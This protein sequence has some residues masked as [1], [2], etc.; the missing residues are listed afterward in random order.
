MT[1]PRK[2]VTVE[3]LIDRANKMLDVSPSGLQNER[4]AIHHFVAGI[5][6]DTGNYKGFNYLPSEFD[7]DGNLRKDYDGSRTFFYK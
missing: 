1:K 3:S 7:T 6:H 4:Y 2:T 5:L